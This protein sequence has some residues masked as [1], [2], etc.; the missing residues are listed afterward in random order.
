MNVRRVSRCSRFDGGQLLIVLAGALGAFGV[1]MVFSTTASQ[2]TD[3][4]AYL[5]RQMTFLGAGLLLCFAA[6]RIPAKYIRRMTVPFLMITIALLVAVLFSRQIKGAHRW[7][8]LPLVGSVQPGELARLSVVLFSAWYVDRYRGSL[9]SQPLRLAVLLGVVAAVCLLILLQPDIGIPFV[10]ATTVWVMLLLVG[11][12]K[13]VLLGLLG[14]GALAVALAVVLAPHRMKRMTAFLNPWRYQAGDGYQL[15]QSYLS[16]SFGHL[17]GRGFGNSQFKENYLPEAHTDFILAII[18]EELGFVGTASV[19]LAFAL[20]FY[21]G[22]R[23]VEQVRSTYAALV[24][25]GLVLIIVL[26][27]YVNF[28]VVI[29]LLPTKGLGLPFI[30][31]GGSSLLANLIAVGIIVG[32]WR[33][34]RVESENTAS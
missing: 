2:R 7:L 20:F 16:L 28:G 9:M 33:Q 22:V 6:V 30:S 17:T 11:V 13:R 4:Y 34:Y 12:R 1:F 27:A 5:Y 24:I 26:Q 18:G 21:L 3:L 15:V 23:L 8:S 10:I 19:V 14:V 29:G 32:L 25:F 31:Y